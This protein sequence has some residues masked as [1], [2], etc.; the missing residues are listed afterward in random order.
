MSDEER[1]F[2]LRP[3]KPKVSRTKGGGW[4][5]G[6]RML[7]HYARQSRGMSR[8]GSSGGTRT[9]AYRQRCAVRITYLK[10]R[11]RGQ[12]RAHGRYLERET[13]AGGETGFNARE[14]DVNISARLQTWQVSKDE[15]L[16]KL[17]ISPEFGERADLERLTRD[18]M[19]RV[20]EDV[21]TS[22]E[23]VAT[24]HRNTEHPH[25]HIAM[26]G[27][28]AD[29]KTLRLSRDYVKRGVRGIA[30]EL[31]TRQ[32]GFRTTLDATE[33]ERREV[34]ET[35]LT[36]L[37]QVILKKA[38]VTE[39]GL[40][41]A[42]E[43]EKASAT[44]HHVSAR[45]IALAR[46]GLAESTAQGSWLL[47]SDTAQVLRAMQRAGDRQKSL[48]AHGELLSDKRLRA[49]VA[50]WRKL[51]SVEGRI[52]G[53]GEDEQS[54][55]SFL[56]LEA[57][58]ARVIYIPYTEEMEERRSLGGLKTNSF[59]RLGRLSTNGRV[60]LE[61]EDLGHSEAVLTNRRRLRE[62]VDELRRQGLRPTED[63][64]GG[65]LG[66]YQKALCEVEADRDVVSREQRINK[67]VRRRSRSLER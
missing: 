40:V 63:G 19:L 66:R 55:R 18:V 2:R 44:T 3:G 13:A 58:S 15:L 29:G 52:L 36:S 7:M 46:M 45:L 57:T 39:D 53:H 61:I 17:I 51:A 43:S 35:R 25:V 14:A 26:R 38:I 37:D 60:K 4:T 24:V 12:W 6:F 42:E 65:W 67:Q 28:A 64:W 27:V 8:Q 22:L 1:E 54:G 20:Q 56:M 9:V 16:W 33:A 48:A 23:W 21:G 62:K 30:E 10:N 5:P 59:I 50:D 47:R 32:M 41:L 49:E 11:T 31:C 34:N